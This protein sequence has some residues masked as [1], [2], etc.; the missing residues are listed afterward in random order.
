MIKTALFTCSTSPALLHDDSDGAGWGSA[1]LLV[2][3]FYCKNV[4]K[5]KSAGLGAWRWAVHRPL[6]GC[7][8]EGQND[9]CV[10]EEFQHYFLVQL[11][12]MF[13][14]PKWKGTLGENVETVAMP[15]WLVFRKFEMILAVLWVVYI[16]RWFWNIFFIFQAYLLLVRVNLL[17]ASLLMLMSEMFCRVSE[18]LSFCFCFV[19]LECQ[20]TRPIFI[21]VPI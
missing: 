8:G 16:Q 17:F 7:R 1:S 13:Q 6:Q 2:C 9:L 19:F 5:T 21:S 12:T 14:Q 3:E 10:D 4:Q 20:S 18:A 11:V 15:S